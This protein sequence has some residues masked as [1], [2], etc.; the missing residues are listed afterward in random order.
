MFRFL[1]AREGGA[2]RNR[3]LGEICPNRSRNLAGD[4][5]AGERGRPG[6]HHR[7]ISPLAGAEHLRSAYGLLQL[8]Q[9]V[10]RGS[11]CSFC[12]AKASGV[13][14]LLAGALRRRLPART[15]GARPSSYSTHVPTGRRRYQRC[16]AVRN[17]RSSR[18]VNRRGGHRTSPDASAIATLRPSGPNLRRLLQRGPF[19]RP[20]RTPSQVTASIQPQAATLTPHSSIGVRYLENSPIRVRGLVSG[21]SY[22]FSGSR[23]VQSVDSR[24]ASSL[25]DTRFFRRA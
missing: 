17:A 3:I 14:I 19:R 21:M 12:F 23:P 11:G 15:T 1:N 8:P 6:R 13:V 25:L 9:S 18:T 7:S 10:D 5:P 24:D 2:D 22:E 4:S 16:V 20:S